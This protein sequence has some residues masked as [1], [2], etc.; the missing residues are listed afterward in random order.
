MQEHKISTAILYSPCR[1][2]LFSD[3]HFFFSWT[4]VSENSPHSRRYALWEKSLWE[5]CTDNTRGQW[6]C[7]R[8]GR[9]EGNGDLWGTVVA[10]MFEQSRAL[11]EA[12]SQLCTNS[13]REIEVPGRYRW[14]T[15]SYKVCCKHPFTC[16]WWAFEIYEISRL[17]HSDATSMNCY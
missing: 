11:Y 9:Y 10:S 12:T 2:E 6:L 3:I 13:Y 4:T 14:I 5:H 1:I 7:Q 15:H 16:Q 17:P 8:K